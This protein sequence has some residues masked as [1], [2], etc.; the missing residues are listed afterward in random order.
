[1]GQFYNNM[2]YTYIFLFHFNPKK[3][4]K[5]SNTAEIVN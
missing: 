3:L 5:S 1:M 4:Q 2:L